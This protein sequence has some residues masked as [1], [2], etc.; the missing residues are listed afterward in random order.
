MLRSREL[1]V[2]PRTARLLRFFVEESLRNDFAPIQQRFIGTHVLGLGDDF[3]PTHSA[4][5]RVNI[6]RMRKAIDGY[7]AGAGRVDAILFTVSQG[8]YRLVVARRSPSEP[9]I[10]PLDARKA[11][12][13]RP[14]VLVVEPQAVGIMDGLD[15]L[16]RGVG[17]RVASL[18]V[19]STLI[20]ASGPL[21]RERLEDVAESAAALAATL[22]YEYVT[23]TSLRI[24]E[25]RWTAGMRI[26]DTLTDQAVGESAGALGPFPDTP[27][28]VEAVATWIYHRIGDYFATIFDGESTEA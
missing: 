23:E 27:A 8:P 9:S 28:A 2:R 22:G 14:L 18:L 17:T 12:R 19:E 10:L 1:V 26:V 15:G 5:V 25:A 24:T 16:T 4:H 21:L 13:R 6:A 20:T 7:Y 11:R 3:H